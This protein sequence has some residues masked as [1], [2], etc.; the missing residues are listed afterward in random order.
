MP[1]Y[2]DVLKHKAFKSIPGAKY[3]LYREVT[4]DTST[5]QPVYYEVS[6]LDEKPWQYLRDIIYPSFSRF[7]KSKKLNPESG[8]GTVVVVFHRNICYLIKGDD[9]LKAFREIEGLNP[10]AFHFRV[11]QWLSQ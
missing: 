1:S 6:L 11:L 7:L 8:E 5:E 10:S 2:I 9:F 4:S 3:N